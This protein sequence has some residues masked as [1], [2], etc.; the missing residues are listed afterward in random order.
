MRHEESRIVI[1]HRPD[2]NV[3]QTVATT[4]D[5]RIGRHPDLDRRNLVGSPAVQTL[6]LPP[7]RQR[8]PCVNLLQASLIQATKPEF[9]HF[10]L[11]SDEVGHHIIAD[12][13]TQL[14]R[15]RTRQ[16]DIVG[17]A[18]VVVRQFAVHQTVP[19]ETQV[20]KRVDSFE[21]QPVNVLIRL[22]QAR[23][24]GHA[25]KTRHPRLFE[26]AFAIGE[27]FREGIQFVDRRLSGLDQ[28]R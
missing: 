24:P 2:D 10:H 3:L 17:D 27:P 26:H 12:A 4:L 23:A 16:Q 7:V 18:S 1:F 25:V 8:H 9:A 6:H 19:E 13:E 20:V 22:D 11:V 15:R 5:R 28:H 14:L 21:I